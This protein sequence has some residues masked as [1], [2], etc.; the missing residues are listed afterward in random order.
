MTRD[1]N[2]SQPEVRSST[3][4]E[5][6]VCSAIGSND[7]NSIMMGRLDRT[8]NLLDDA[9]SRRTHA[10]SRNS[11]DAA[12]TYEMERQAPLLNHHEI[13]HGQQSVEDCSRFRSSQFH[14]PQSAD[15]SNKHKRKTRLISSPPRDYCH[16]GMTSPEIEEYA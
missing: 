10:A 8:A 2:G 12:E 11:R 9:T 16:N 14:E 4:F 13:I 1:G 15:I 7:K 3:M 6:P 5:E